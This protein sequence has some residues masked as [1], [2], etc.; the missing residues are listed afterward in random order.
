MNIIQ[1][2][3]AAENGSLITNNFLKKNNRFLKYMKGG[4]F[5]EYELVNKIPMF[6]YSIINFSMADV[7]SIGWEILP[8]NPFNL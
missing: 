2:I 8:T 3:Q 4:T 5:Y 7:I 6:K 1:A